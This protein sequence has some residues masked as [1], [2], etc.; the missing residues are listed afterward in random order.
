MASS[1]PGRQIRIA[2]YGI[3]VTRNAANLPQTTSGNL[4]QVIGGRILLT[5]IVGEVTSVLQTLANN[6]RLQ[7]VN[8]MGTAVTD[9]CAN[10]DITGRG[11]GV[12]FGITGTPSSPM[13]DGGS[14]PQTSELV[15]QT[16]FIRLTTAASATG[17]IKW[18]VTYIPLDDGAVVTAV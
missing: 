3:T 2:K 5:T 1:I 15:V 9:M 13:L 12:L 17:Q 7:A 8:S 10:A 11:V 6:T 16:G 14:V 4:F 18:L